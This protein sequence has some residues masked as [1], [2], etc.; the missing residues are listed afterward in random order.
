MTRPRLRALQLAL[1]AGALL[2][3]GC[4][5]D[6]PINMSIDNVPSSI[7]LGGKKPP[8]VTVAP[9]PPVA[10]PVAPPL[11]AAL[12]GLTG[13]PAYGGLPQ[14]GSSAGGSG[15]AACPTA[16]PLTPVRQPLA[17]AVSLP[18]G[19]AN[20]SFRNHGDYEVSGANAR[21]GHFP[22]VATRTV[23][24]V[25]QVQNSTTGGPWYVFDVDVVMG[26]LETVTTY[27][28]VPEG[29]SAGASTASGTGLFLSRVKTHYADGTSQDFHPVDTPGLLL[30]PF[31]ATPGS[32]WNAAGADPT[33]GVSMSFAGT[34]ARKV[35]VDACGTIL[36]AWS[37]HL[38]GSVRPPSP[39][40]APTSAPTPVPL[41]SQS[42][43]PAAAGSPGE[44]VQFVADYAFVPQYGGLS[45][46]DVVS[47]AG[48]EPQSGF[49]QD[50]SSTID[51]EPVPPSAAVPTCQGTCPP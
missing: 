6:L 31:P 34:I 24:N 26:G 35:S 8:A 29:G 30:L 12:P 13:T 3:T 49:T 11:L 45:V 7:V 41:P 51:S 23:E 5:P 21:S 48:S 39:S 46:N 27:T 50:D 14:P 44:V 2:L 18:P 17:N 25:H 1:V 15:P 36:D 47:I 19:A 43:A 4:G 9:I 16:N 32:S 28:I 37:V 10:L 38:D 20:Y 33:T 22:P 42:P 40:G